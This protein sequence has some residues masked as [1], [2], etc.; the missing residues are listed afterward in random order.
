MVARL[1]PFADRAGGRGL[2]AGAGRQDVRRGA[3]HPLR[4][5]SSRSTCRRSSACRRAAAS[6]ISLKRWKARTRSQIGQ[7]HAGPDRRGQPGPEADPR[8]LD[9]H[10]DQSVALSRHRSRQGA[11]AGCQ[12]RPTCSPRCRRR[13]AGSM[14]TT[15]IC[16][17]APGRS[18]SRARRPTAATFRVDLA[19]L[20]AQQS[21]ARWCRCA[22]S[23][24]CAS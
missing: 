17:A 6:N 21:T 19:D 11:G 15:S 2:G 3:A 22:R 24:I 23:P 18:T 4:G 16:S 9:L 10:R 5:R 20:R 13:W 8:V 12:Y 14:S 7:R 1:K